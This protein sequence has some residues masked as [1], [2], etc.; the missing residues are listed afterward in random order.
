MAYMNIDLSGEFDMNPRGDMNIPFWVQVLSF[1]GVLY[2]AWQEVLPQ[3]GTFVPLDGGRYGTSTQNPVYEANGALLTLGNYYPVQRADFNSLDTTYVVL[4][5]STSFPAPAGL[6]VELSDGTEVVTG[7]TTLQLDPPSAWTVVDEGGGVARATTSPGIAVKQSD[8]NHAVSGVSTLILDQVTG[9]AWEA[10][11]ANTY[12]VQLLPATPTQDGMVTTVAQFFAG[13]KT[14][15]GNLAVSTNIIIGLNGFPDPRVL[16]FD[17]D[18]DFA[19]IFWRSDISLSFLTLQANFT[20]APVTSTVN[21]EL[22]PGSTSRYVLLSATD[23]NSNTLVTTH[24]DACYAVEDHTGTPF[25]GGYAVTGG[26]TFKGGL[27]ISGTASGGLTVGSSTVSGG[28]TSGLLYTDGTHLQ[29]SS[30]ARVTPAGNLGLSNTQP[31]AGDIANSQAVFW[32]K[33]S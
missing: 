18:P 29:T 9:I 27:Y 31:A 23:F 16:Q 14:F 8:G 10:N 24:F 2:Y 4:G 3:G 19:L 28:T 6:V 30:G 25:V 5:E 1:D 11:T 22:V 21:F 15:Y 7:V 13:F 17:G 12:T 32:A 26:L 20:A 33:T